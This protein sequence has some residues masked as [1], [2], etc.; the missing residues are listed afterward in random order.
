MNQ[1]IK[2][3]TFSD[4]EILFQILSKFRITLMELE[5][6]RL[7]ADLELLTVL[8]ELNLQLANLVFYK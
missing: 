3:F 8:D 1:S 6:L 7:K 2:T 5:A 4:I